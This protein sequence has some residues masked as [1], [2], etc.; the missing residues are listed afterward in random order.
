MMIINFKALVF[1]EMRYQSLVVRIKKAFI[2]RFF[3]LLFVKGTVQH[4]VA[5]YYDK[6]QLNWISQLSF[7]V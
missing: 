1:A 2:V 7:P 3:F 6:F 5:N 4:K